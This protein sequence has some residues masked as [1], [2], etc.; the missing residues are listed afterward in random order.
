MLCQIICRL[1]NLLDSKIVL[2]YRFLCQSSDRMKTRPS[3]T[4]GQVSCRPERGE[5]HLL[6]DLVMLICGHTLCRSC[7]TKTS[8]NQPRK[9][10]TNSGS[11]GKTLVSFPLQRPVLFV[12]NTFPAMIVIKLRLVRTIQVT[13]IA[14][15][16]KHMHEENHVK[17]RTKISK[18]KSFKLWIS[19]NS[20]WSSRGKARVRS[21]SNEKSWVNYIKFWMNAWCISVRNWI[22]TVK[23]CRIY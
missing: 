8:D 10:S 6:N 11:V 13:T 14:S 3:F 4:R 19:V 16:I 23:N 1:L 17:A 2:F 22:N 20:C 15:A 12:P 21:R 9:F 7:T 5:A 18:C